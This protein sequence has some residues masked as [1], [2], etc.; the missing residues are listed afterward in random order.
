MG[1]MVHFMKPA[2]PVAG[3]DTCALENVGPRTG[4]KPTLAH[5]ASVEGMGLK[6]RSDKVVLKP[7]SLEELWVTIEEIHPL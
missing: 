4:E 7:S 6:T 1:A 5:R 3:F 2:G